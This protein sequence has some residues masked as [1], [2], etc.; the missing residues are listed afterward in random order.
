[1][2]ITRTNTVSGQASYRT[3]L[4]AESDGDT[5]FSFANP[6]GSIPAGQGAFA[7]EPPKVTLVPMSE[8]AR[9]SD[10]INTVVNAT[11][12]TVVKASTGSSGDA[13]AQLRIWVEIPH[14]LV[15]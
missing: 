1:M 9:L 2:A 13:A 15:R 5:T 3:D 8:E 10:W 11:T 6:F 14:S 12:I 7:G 4:I